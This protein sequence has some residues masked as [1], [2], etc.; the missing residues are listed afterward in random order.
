M[1]SNARIH[2]L[3]QKHQTLEAE[4]SDL[5]ASP[6]VTDDQIAAL[7]RQKLQI[8]DEIGRLRAEAA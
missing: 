8:K 7:K 4:L 6:S 1:S 5:M 2:S 3:E